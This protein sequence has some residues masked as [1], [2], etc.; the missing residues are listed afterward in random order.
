METAVPSR[1]TGCRSIGQY[2]KDLSFENP[3]APMGH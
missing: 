3:G 2:V 1:N